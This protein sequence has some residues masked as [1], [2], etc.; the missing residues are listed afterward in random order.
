MHGRRVHPIGAQPI[1]A[2]AEDAKIVV[3]ELSDRLGFDVVDAGPLAGVALQARTSG[4]RR[5]D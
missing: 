2:D 3:A 4:A 5:R 1:T